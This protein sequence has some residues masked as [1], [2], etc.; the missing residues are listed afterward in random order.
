MAG[1]EPV[2]PLRV[3]T[4]HDRLLALGVGIYAPDAEV[5]AATQVHIN[6]DLHALAATIKAHATTVKSTPWATATV[7]GESKELLAALTPGQL[8][9]AGGWD[10]WLSTRQLLSRDAD[11]I[12]QRWLE[13]V[14]T[15]PRNPAAWRAGW[16]HLDFSW[17]QQGGNLI[18]TLRRC[19]TDVAATSTSALA[20]QL[21]SASTTDGVPFLGAVAVS[22][23]SLARAW[24]AL[25]GL[26][27]LPATPIGGTCMVGDPL[28]NV[29]TVPLN[30]GRLGELIDNT[31]PEVDHWMHSDPLVRE[32]CPPPLRLEWWA[33][34]VRSVGPATVRFPEPISE[35]AAKERLA[36][37]TGE[38]TVVPL[39]NTEVRAIR[40]MCG[41]SI[42]EM[43]SM[44]SISDRTIRRWETGAAIPSWSAARAVW[45]LVADLETL[46][47]VIIAAAAEQTTETVDIDLGDGAGAATEL[48]SPAGS[49]CLPHGAA[50]PQWAEGLPDGFV[51]AA[52]AKAALAGVRLR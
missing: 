14:F 30:V 35:D 3:T 43:A 22:D 33:T 12:S 51:L 48:H 47:G 29:F 27:A 13:A 31:I 34:S 4:L 2:I 21:T 6:L 20:E 38:S 1:L 37:R 50:R 11:P 49:V 5:T 42:S 28:D 23:M 44:L 45:G 15:E 46:T 52:A 39:T 25:V 9:K 32:S 8:A 41:L 24:L 16:T 40:Q 19:A 26:A 18:R 7:P 36:Q 17:P 10:A